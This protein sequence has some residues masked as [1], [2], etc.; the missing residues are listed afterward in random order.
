M[1]D[2]RLFVVVPGESKGPFFSYLCT[3]ALVT[4][5][6]GINVNIL[7][8]MG[9]DLVAVRTTGIRAALENGATH[10]LWVDSDILMQPDA[11]LRLFQH[12]L[13]A[14]AANYVIKTLEFVPVS[15]DEEGERVDSVG[16]KGLEKVTA[17]GLG[18]FLTDAKIYEKM[19][20]PWFGHRWFYAGDKDPVQIGLPKEPKDWPA[21]FEDAYFSDRIREAGYDIWIDHDLSLELGHYGGSIYYHDKVRSL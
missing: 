1:S 4:E 12:N 15:S 6:N 9:S 13:P 18:F 14:V 3:M 10:V 2:I 8:P 17:T 11:A 7:N 16:K 21:S 19:R 20:W 5:R